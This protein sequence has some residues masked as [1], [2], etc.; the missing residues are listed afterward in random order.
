MR[1]AAPGTA[2][3]APADVGWTFDTFTLVRSDAVGDG[4]QRFVLEAPYIAGRATP[5]QFV[6]LGAAAASPR[7]AGW[8]HLSHPFFLASIDP[9]L[10]QIGVVF[11]RAAPF[12]WDM[13][14]WPAG[15]QVE[16]IG[17]LGRGF[18]QPESVE[19]PLLLLGSG[20][21]LG[22]LAAVA[23]G[24]PQGRG[25]H[26]RV[27]GRPPASP[28]W[29]LLVGPDSESAA[30]AQLRESVTAALAEPYLAGA[31]AWAA[32]PAAFTREVARQALSQGRTCLVTAEAP[33]ACAVGACLGC[34]SAGDGTWRTCREGPV[35]PAPWLKGVDDR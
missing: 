26:V 2:G 15:T 5:G 33:I 3:R 9:E 19:G 4:W 29:A 14:G 10:G 11:D 7:A 24:L 18:P 32:G 20:Y 25:A 27:V 30:L 31:Q 22:A 6:M 8:E 12:A 21:G 35:V 17:P 1:S 28:D 13:K 23:K 34:T 16:L